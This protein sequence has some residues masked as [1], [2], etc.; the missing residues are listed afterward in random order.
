MYTTVAYRSGAVKEDDKYL[1]C[2]ILKDGYIV[3]EKGVSF[4]LPELIKAQNKRFA[5]DPT[6]LRIDIIHPTEKG[7]ILRRPEPSQPQVVKPS[8]CPR[9]GSY[10]G[11]STECPE[12][13]HGQ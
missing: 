4:N 1:Q 11:D 5:T 8:G 7:T 3:E 12:C 6:L 2:T 9:C 10:E 13:G